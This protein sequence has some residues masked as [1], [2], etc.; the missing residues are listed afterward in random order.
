LASSKPT[1]K[2]IRPDLTGLGQQADD[3]A[4]IHPTRQKHADR[5]VGDHPAL[6]RDTQA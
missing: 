5:H 3:Q 4:R 2:L 6:D 1:E